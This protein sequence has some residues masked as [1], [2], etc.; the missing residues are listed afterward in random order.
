LPRRLLTNVERSKLRDGPSAADWFAHI[1]GPGTRW[2]HK[3]DIRDFMIYTEIREA[4]EFQIILGVHV[5][6]AA[7]HHRTLTANA[8]ND[9][10]FNE[11]FP[12]LT[13]AAGG[14]PR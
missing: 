1:E 4:M 5:I 2:I 3:T 10:K 6:G 9:R 13:G 14:M 11:W 7:C 12:G 8:T